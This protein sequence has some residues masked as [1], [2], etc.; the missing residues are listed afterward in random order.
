MDKHTPQ[1]YAFITRD[2]FY[3]FKYE[4]TKIN[5]NLGYQI[6]GVAGRITLVS[7][8]FTDFMRLVV[9]DII[10]R[11]V[12]F[13]LPVYGI[14]ACKMQMLAIR[15][16]KF[17]KLMQCGKWE[18]LDFV[19]T[20]FTGYQIYLFMGGKNVPRTKPVYINRKYTK[21]MIQKLNA[22]FPYGDGKID[23]TFDDYLDQL[24]E[25]YPLVSKSDLKKV[26][27][28]G[29]KMLYLNNSFGADVLI[30]G[31]EPYFW[32]YFGEEHANMLVHYKYYLRKLRT[33]LRILSNRKN[34]EWD[35]Y[36]YFAVPLYKYD[37]YAGQLQR[38]TKNFSFGDVLLYQRF[39][40]CN[41]SHPFCRYVFRTKIP[42]YERPRKFCKDFKSKCAELYC[43]RKP[44]KF[45]DI[46]TS[47][48]YYEFL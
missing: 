20:N 17:Q 36:Y 23:T 30:K 47:K 2:L 46:Y 4:K 29:C 25:K 13:I 43:V 44:L 6:T 18:G 16:K 48:N 28:Y 38:G 35:G 22:G 5:S 41:L 15:G 12:T 10:D 8:I 34:F 32:C 9:E 42:F 33:K 27:R 21:K 1:G 39:D 37:D 26:V 11:N 7:R 40:D 19:K 45:K 24:A 14:R 31:G 3:K